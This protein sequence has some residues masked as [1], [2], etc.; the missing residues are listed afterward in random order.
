MAVRPSHQVHRCPG[1]LREARGAKLPGIFLLALLTSACASSSSNLLALEQ[2][3]AADR[4][5]QAL[6]MLENDKRH[7]ARRD[8]VLY[9]LNRAML[10]RMN[11]N[12]RASNEAFA[13]AQRRIDELYGVS[14][15]EQAGS[16][17]INDA[18]RQYIG[19]EFEQMLLHVY[20]ALNY[21]ELNRPDEARVEALQIDLKLRELGK[22]IDKQKY[23][24]DAF[25]RYLSGLIYEQHGEWSDA[26]I[27]YR[28]AY[29]AYRLYQSQYGV[30]VPRMLQ[31]DLVRLADKLGLQDE[32]ER[33]RREF[34]ID[35][36]QT[37]EQR[38]SQG[39]LVFT[40]HN[41]LAPVKREESVIL[42]VPTTYTLV[43]ISLP[44]YQSRSAPAR[45][46]RLQIGGNTVPLELV[47]DVDAMAH[48]TLEIKLP[49]IQA[50]ALTRAGVKA[51]VAEG[52][53]RDD[54]WLL[55]MLAEIGGLISERADTRSWLTLPHDI[56]LARVVLPPGKYNLKL[57]LLDRY[58]AVIIEQEIPAVTVEQGRM[59]FVS[60]HRITPAQL[61]FRS[62]P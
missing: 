17:I 45:G 55:G 6:R 27:E 20:M 46:A 36:W 15:S 8:E 12:L 11:G 37:V 62:L 18:T 25:G 43:R 28:R 33:Y 41:G 19:E 30:A 7:W 56:L 34:T 2:D 26:M 58:Q 23:I 3:L 60:R 29:E 35:H 42:P 61:I 24:E 22:K 31:R 53:K 57:E 51:I 9:W 44:Y 13:R 39:E 59:T 49:L 4:P 21:L 38:Q 1:R 54:K 40:L 10:L 47:E 14:V 32:L 50:R 52:L 5:D 16:W 48:K